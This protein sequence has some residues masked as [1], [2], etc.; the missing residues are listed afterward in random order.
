MTPRAIFILS[1]SISTYIMTQDDKPK[2]QVDIYGDAFIAQKKAR[3][4]YSNFTMH[5]SLNGEKLVELGLSSAPLNI[6]IYLTVKMEFG[7]L[8]LINQSEYSRKLNISRNSVAEAV[9]TLINHNLI[10]KTEQRKGTSFFYMVNP[11]YVFK[12]KWKDYQ[13]VFDEYYDLTNNLGKAS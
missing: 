13:K 3:A 7:N 11:I 8:V 1:Y 9:K 10:K 4:V 5:N 12:G 2:Y 6:F